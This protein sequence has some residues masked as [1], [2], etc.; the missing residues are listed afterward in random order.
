MTEIPLQFSI[1]DLNPTMLKKRKSLKSNNLFNNYQ[2]NRPKTCKGTLPIITVPSFSNFTEKLLHMATNKKSTT[3]F[4]TSNESSTTQI[5]SR[6]FNY[7]RSNVTIKSKPSITYPTTT[8]RPTTSYRSNYQ[9]QQNTQFL[10]VVNTPTSTTHQPISPHIANT[11]FNP[12]PQQQQH[13]NSQ[14]PQYQYGHFLAHLRRQSLARTRRKQEQGITDHIETAITF[15]SNKNQTFQSPSN[16][17]L[18]SLTSDSSSTPTISITA[19]RAIRPL[20]NYRQFQ[21]S[22]KNFRL[23]SFQQSQSSL[24]SKELIDNQL[25]SLQ[26]SSLLITPRNSVVDDTGTSTI[27]KPSY[28]LHINDDMLNYCYVSGDS[29]VKY[30]GQMFPTAF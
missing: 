4:N 20:S 22:I 8:I 25:L 15:N 11:Y 26:S 3:P 10:Y 27:V 29:G 23:N 21:R 24:T 5:K 9:S 28:D 1:I 12:S 19:K 14:R 16:Y 30:Q 17:S 7:N 2:R 13:Q 6:T 18:V